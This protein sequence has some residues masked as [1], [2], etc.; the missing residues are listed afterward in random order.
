VNIEAVARRNL[1]QLEISTRSEDLKVPPGNRLDAL[2]GSRA[3]QCHHRGGATGIIRMRLAMIEPLATA[4]VLLA[5]LYLACLGAVSLAAPALARRFLLGFARSRARHYLELAVRLFVGG[6]FLMCAPVVRFPLA[7]TAFGWAIVI[8]T[9]GLALVPWRWHRRFAQQA[10]PRV[11]Q[12]LPLLGL[13]S[14]L[15][16]G[17]VLFALFG[18]AH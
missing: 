10:V 5:G 18:S 1:R 4:V 8:T 16:G 2:K 11:L 15:L 9:V 14:L 13:A 3:G 12:Y 17:F 6:A 7:F